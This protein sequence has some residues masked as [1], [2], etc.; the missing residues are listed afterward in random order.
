MKQTHQVDLNT[1]NENIR[2]IHIYIPHTGSL[3]LEV[4]G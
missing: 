3:W 1:R 2:Y 4:L